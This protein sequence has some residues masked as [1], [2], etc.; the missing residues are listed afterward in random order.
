MSDSE[1]GNDSTSNEPPTK[2]S[3]MEESALIEIQGRASGGAEQAL[4]ADIGIQDVENLHLVDE[5][6]PQ[7]ELSTASSESESDDE[8]CY[9]S[10]VP[11]EEIDALLE[12]G[13][14]DEMKGPRSQRVNK[15][16]DTDAKPAKE[17]HFERREKVMLVEKAVNHFEVLPEGW[18][19]V[20]HNSGM[21]IYLH[22][23]SRVCTFSRPYFLG[24]GSVRKHRI[25]LSAIPCLK[26]MRDLDSEK[27]PICPRQQDSEDKA[28]EANE[29]NAESQRGDKTEDKEEE[30]TTNNSPEESEGGK[31]EEENLSIPSGPL[32]KAL[33]TQAVFSP[34]KV[35]SDSLVNLAIA[36]P[37][38]ESVVEA[39]KKHS[40][41]PEELREYC[42]K[43]FQFKTIKLL[44]F[45]T[46]GDKRRYEKSMKWRNRPQLPEGTKLI[47]LRRRGTSADDDD[48]TFRSRK[49]WVI[50]PKGKSYVCIL[51]EYVQHVLKNQP[52]YE[53]KEV[54]NASTPYAAS[55]SINDVLYCTGYGSSKKQAKMEAAKATLEILLPEL[56][57]K[58]RIEKNTDEETDLS[59]F[60]EIRI[61]DPRVPELCNKTSELSPYSILLNCLQRNFG[62][63]VGNI[64]C[65]LVTKKNQKNEFIMS[66]GKHTVQVSCR[67]KKDGKQRASQAILQKLHPHITSWG[68]LLRLY[69][70]R[71]L[72][73][74]RERK[75]E[76]Q[77]VTLLQTNATLHQPNNSII[78]KLK[79][80]MLK[81]KYLKD[82]IQPI[83]KFLPP[84]NILPP[85]TP[86]S[87]LNNVDI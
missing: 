55:I 1:S 35:Q 37:R 24:S 26:Y 16:N 12:E 83:G 41:E 45:R 15:S 43:R 2:K 77:E 78:N 39:E 76:E 62:L 48:S 13:L 84:E 33:A 67:N 10:E 60:D 64:E 11:E 65:R 73:T 50:N 8:S 82:N 36:E 80:E 61:E 81:L 63:S 74:M 66:V 53:F 87:E 72:Q 18:V 21:P 79:Q 42:E 54:E 59:F 22:K 9:D 3:K 31:I 28:E 69:G 47:S 17:I 85:S 49:E 57:K 27:E 7:E 4:G 52:K 51:H 70:N 38:V 34:K 25:P 19:E 20:T 71:S 6:G 30:N 32:A 23:E 58:I 44:R 29:A 75:A 40:L 5:I 56:G 86:G 14:P 46:W 68:S